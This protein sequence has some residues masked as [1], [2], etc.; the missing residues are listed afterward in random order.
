MAKIRFYFHSLL[1]YSFIHCARNEIVDIVVVTFE[2]FELIGKLG[3]LNFLKVLCIMYY[4][5]LR[6]LICWARLGKQ[7]SALFRRKVLIF[8]WLLNWDACYMCFMLYII[9]FFYIFMCCIISTLYY[10]IW[11]YVMC[12]IHGL[13]GASIFRTFFCFGLFHIFLPHFRGNRYI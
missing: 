5:G 6:V 13:H 10:M 1:P 8:R 7:F 12:F 9:L 4:T 2:V 11:H 3:I